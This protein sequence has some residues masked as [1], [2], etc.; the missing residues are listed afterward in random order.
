MRG[1]GDLFGMYVPGASWLHRLPAWAKYLIVLGGSLPV[2][3]FQELWLSVVMAG[4]FALLL[5]TTGIR[6]GVTLRLGWMVLAMA[7]VLVAY[8]AFATHWTTGAMLAA[9]LVACIWAARV[10]IL[11]TPGPELV[12]ALVASF[13]PLRWVGGS[14][15][16]MGLAVGIMLRSIPHLMGSFDDVRDACRA[17]GIER[18]LVAQVTPVVVGAVAYAH[19]TGEA[20]AARGLGD[21]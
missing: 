12:D 4:V 10:L 7:A 2:L 15:E 14:P 9:N 8:H 16:R 13:A 5:L 18:N 19:A 1:G 11:T 21:D 17:R 6:P 20:L 3:I